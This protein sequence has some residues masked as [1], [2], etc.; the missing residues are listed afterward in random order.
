MTITSLLVD[1]DDDDGD[2]EDDKS[3]NTLYGSYYGRR[4]IRI[5]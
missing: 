5:P 3:R 4:D 1:Y 2:G